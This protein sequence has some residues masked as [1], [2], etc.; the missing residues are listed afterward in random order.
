MLGAYK[1]DSSLLLRQETWLA[2]LPLLAMNPPHQTPQNN[3]DRRSKRRRIEAGSPADTV[4]S[5]GSYPPPL[6]PPQENQRASSDD[7]DEEIHL[8][9]KPPDVAFVALTR[10]TDSLPPPPYM[11]QCMIRLQRTD[12]TTLIMFTTS[13][14]LMTQ[15]A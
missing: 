3:H 4:P 15:Y 6:N 1:L 10:P 8:H 9:T 2:N 5:R 14:G 11:L 13:R 12:A 7:N